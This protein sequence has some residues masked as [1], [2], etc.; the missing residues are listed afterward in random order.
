MWNRLF[1]AL[2]VLAAVAA[3]SRAADFKPVQCEG[4]YKF[5]LQGVCRSEDSLFW[6]FTSEL[7][8]T[9]SEGKIQKQIPVPGHHGDLAWHDGQVYVAVYLRKAD[10]AEGEPESWVYVYDAND[11]ALVTR[12]P[13]VEAV[14]RA[15]G[16]AHHDGRYVIVGGLPK[17]LEEN[18]A[19]E[20]DAH[21]KFVK[22]HV[23]ASGYTNLGIQAAAFADGHWWFGCYGD[24]LLK[25]DES[26]GSVERFA[27]DG[28]EGMVPLS[29][30][31]FLVARGGK[32][33]DQGYT[34]RL[35]P[36]RTDPERGLVIEAEAK[37]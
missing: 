30:G 18:V 24:V 12:H 10:R 17:G 26:L 3:A 35:V 8:K 27:F 23:L 31:R 4:N 19:F 2:S 36:A 21:F 14:H 33:P 25:A 28:A 5:H 16:I 15:G 37:P 7:V 13:A 1:L 20:Y 29:A 6:C 22:K 9:D 32:V 34:G 11:L